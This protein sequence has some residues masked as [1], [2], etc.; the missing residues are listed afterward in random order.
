WEVLET[1]EH[2]QTKSEIKRLNDELEQRVE[3]RT[4]DLTEANRQLRRALEE[5][6]K[7]RQRLESENA[8]LREEVSEASGSSILGNSDGLLHALEQV[9]MVAPTEATVLI[10]GETGVGKELI[11]RAI[12]EHSPRRDHPLIKVNCT[13]IPRELFES[14]F[15][16]HVK[17]AFS[18]ATRD[19][20]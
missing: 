2:K 5:I 19:R 11:A 18:G 4:R 3:E 10:S 6:G 1:P 16:G 13:A 17:G 7:L 20:I 14:E 15:F 8:Y 12:H 9:E